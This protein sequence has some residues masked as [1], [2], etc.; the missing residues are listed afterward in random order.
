MN[1]VWT[2]EVLRSE[3]FKLGSGHTIAENTGL[4]MRS[5]SR[6]IFRER[7]P[8]S[9][10]Q[11]VWEVDKTQSGGSLTTTLGAGAVGGLALGGIG[12]IGGLLL[13]S[14]RVSET[15]VYVTLTDGRDFLAAAP[16]TGARCLLSAAINWPDKPRT[17]SGDGFE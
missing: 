14:R 8:L 12:L 13:G 9:Q 6:K 1:R 15:V 3:F 10:V 16:P 5:Y 7:L 4:F 11:R 2:F 17:L